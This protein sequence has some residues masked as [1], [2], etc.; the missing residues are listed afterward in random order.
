MK[1][2]NKHFFR[3][4]RLIYCSTLLV[5]QVAIPSMRFL[6]ITWQRYNYFGIKKIIA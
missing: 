3:A 5:L 1:I 4:Y 6:I 2:E